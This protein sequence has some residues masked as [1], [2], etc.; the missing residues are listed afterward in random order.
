MGWLNRLTS[1]Y[2]EVFLLIRTFTLTNYESS[3][4]I[5]SV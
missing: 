2:S 3:F 5:A 1:S 4:T